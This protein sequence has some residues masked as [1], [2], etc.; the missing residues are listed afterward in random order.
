MK[1]KSIESQSSQSTPTQALLTISFPIRQY[2]NIPSICNQG[3]TTC[4]EGLLPLHWPA[5]LLP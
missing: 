1:M 3:R 4:E 2:F 5:L